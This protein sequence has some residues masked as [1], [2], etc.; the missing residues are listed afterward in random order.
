MCDVAEPEDAFNIDEY[1][2]F[3]NPSKPIVYMS[4]KEIIDTHAVSNS[5][6][7]LGDKSVYLTNVI[8][9]FFLF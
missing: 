9:I 3:V 1:S 6:K 5:I 2:D 8:N 7:I 4:V